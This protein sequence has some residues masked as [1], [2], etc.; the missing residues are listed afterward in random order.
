MKGEMTLPDFEQK[1]A[2]GAKKDE[3][4]AVGKARFNAKTPRCEGAKKTGER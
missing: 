3:G 1:H 2:K 4:L